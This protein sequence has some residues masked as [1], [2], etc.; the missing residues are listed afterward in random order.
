[1]QQLIAHVH[2]LNGILSGENT[3]PPESLAGT[4]SS[5]P[6]RRYGSCVSSTA[7]GHRLRDSN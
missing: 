1:M 7:R 6:L 5:A 2:A 3:P 4:Q